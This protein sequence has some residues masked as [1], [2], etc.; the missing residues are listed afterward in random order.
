MQVGFLYLEVQENLHRIGYSSMD[1]MEYNLMKFFSSTY[2][3][4]IS[5]MLLIIDDSVQG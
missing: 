1:E 2:Y 5:H 4:C 3:N